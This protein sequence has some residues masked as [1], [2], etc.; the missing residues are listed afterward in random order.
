MG[1]TH[2][3]T[4][5]SVGIDL[6]GTNLRAAVFRGDQM[7]LE[8]REAVGTRRDP[9][10]IANRIADFV[11]ENSPRSAPVGVGLA[12]MLRGFNGDVAHSPHLE[13]R[14]TPFGDLLRARLPGRR[15]GVYNDVNAITYGEYA[16]GAA[17]GARH[18]VAVFVGTGIGGGLITNGRLLTGSSNTAAE[19]GH[20][21]VVLHDNARRCNCGLRGCVEA[22]VGG[23]YL[24]ARFREELTDGAR[25]LA[26][27]LAG[28]D[29]Q[30]VT[31]G[32]V[33]EA[34]RRGDPWAS[35]LWHE[36]APL[37]GAAL[38][39][40][41]TSFNPEV[42]VLGGGVL[43]HAPVLRTMAVESCMRLVNPPARAG[44]Q[45]V[46]AALGDNAGLVGA[47]LLAARG[48]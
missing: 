2:K 27:D 42:L 33:D 11:A 25:S 24:L 29:A 31:T 35:A 9:E 7:V 37:L 10:S 45:I 13:W 19:L 44:L 18:V 43:R 46:D 17:R 16:A 21:K 30:A 5:T 48:R 34:A 14:D 22:Y 41:C 15:V 38:A 23:I 6:G 26:L 32:H 39:N 3:S 12:A 20:L 40:T 8:H 47:A 36:I 4:R 1:G 28:G